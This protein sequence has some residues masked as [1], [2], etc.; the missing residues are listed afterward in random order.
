MQ[1]E[2]ERGKGGIVEIEMMT[3]NTNRETEYS[4]GNECRTGRKMRGKL[5]KRSGGCMDETDGGCGWIDVDRWTDFVQQR[6][7]PMPSISSR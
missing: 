2:R 1:K 5:N 7:Q 6:Q 4:R 3:R